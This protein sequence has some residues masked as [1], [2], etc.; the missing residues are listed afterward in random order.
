MKEPSFLLLQKLPF[1]ESRVCVGGSPAPGRNVPLTLWPLSSA[2][3]EQ[4]VPPTQ[5]G[6]GVGWG[7]GLEPFYSPLGYKGTSLGH[8]RS[9][10]DS[11][12]QM[13]VGREAKEAQGALPLTRGD[14][15]GEDG[16]WGGRS[17][18]LPSPC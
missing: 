5:V 1:P 6:N 7:L 12:D 10:R 14:Y 13:D 18:I 8:S 11:P 15:A 16:Q 17:A 4:S 9:S 3:R 2:V